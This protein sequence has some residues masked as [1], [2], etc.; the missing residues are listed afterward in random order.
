MKTNLKIYWVCLLA[1]VLSLC[2]SSFLILETGASENDANKIELNT[3]TTGKLSGNE[4]VNHFYFEV[5]TQGKLTLR[6]FAPDEISSEKSW[7]IIVLNCANDH[8]LDTGVLG[9]SGEYIS[10]SRVLSAGTYFIVVKN[11]NGETVSLSEYTLS[12]IFEEDTNREQE[13]NNSMA[14]ANSMEQNVHYKGRII[15]P[16]D[17]DY[18]SFVYE[19][20]SSVLVFNHVTGAGSTKLWGV[21]LFDIDGRPLGD[22]KKI[23]LNE[24]E[25][26][27]SLAEYELES[28]SQYYVLVS[29]VGGLYSPSEYTILL[30]T[31]HVCELVDVGEEES[32]CKTTGTIAHR[33][34]RI[35]GKN[36]NSQGEEI[37]NITSPLKDHSWGEWTEKQIATCTAGGRQER[38]CLN[39]NKTDS[40]NTDAKGHD[41]Q[42]QWTVDVEATCG[43]DGEKSHH[44]SRC[45]SRDQIT[46]I[47]KKSDAH[48][49]EQTIT[50]DQVR[51][52]DQE[53][54]F[55]R[56][57]RN[58]S[59]RTDVTVEAPLGH[60]MGSPT[61]RV[62]ASCS[63]SGIERTFCSR[64]DHFE[65]R[66]LD[67]LDHDF[68]NEWTVDQAP[69]CEGEGLESRHC[70]RCAE[71][72]EAR[73]IPKADHASE[74]WIFIKAPTCLEQ[75]KLQ[76][77]CIQCRS[78]IYK[79]VDALGH[80]YAEMWETDLIP[81][82]QSVGSESRHCRRC[83]SRTNVR[84]I[85]ALVHS[86]DV[87]KYDEISHWYECACGEKLL[88]QEHNFQVFVLEEATC[89]RQG[90]AKYVCC[91]C[92][93]R[94]EKELP[95][96]E[97]RMGEWTERLPATCYQKGERVRECVSGCGDIEI[98]YLEKLP[99]S[100]SD[101]W[102]VDRAP[103]CEQEG[104]QSHHCEF[105]D[106]RTD[107]VPIPAIGHSFRPWVEIIAP[108][109]T[110]K[111]MKKR[112][113]SRCNAE[114]LLE[115]V[116]SHSYDEYFTVDIEA[117]CETPGSKSRH[118]RNCDERVDVT[119]LSPTGHSYGDWI[120]ISSPSCTEKGAE[121]RTCS[122]CGSVEL[123]NVGTVQNHSFEEQFTVDAAATCEATGSKSRHCRNCDE[124]IDVTELPPTGHSYGDWIEISSPT[125]TEKGV[126]KR[127]CS[128]CGSEELQFVGTVLNHCFEE[129]FTVDAEAT[130]E[131]AGSK[132]RHCRNCD[133]RTDVT[134]LSPTGHLFG[135]WTETEV[136]TCLAAAR[137]KRSCSVCQKVEWRAGSDALGHAFERTW[138]VDIQ[139]SCSS[140]G[141][142]SRHCTRCEEATDREVIPKLEHAYDDGVVRVSPTCE[143]EGIKIFTCT[144]C[145][146]TYEI[147]LEKL[148]PVILDATE[149]KWK[150]KSEES[151]TFRS[152]A[153]LADFLE[154]R[155]NGEIVSE[156]CYI[157]REGST[158]V[159]L[160]PEYLKTLEGGVYTLEI[161]S[162]TG[163]AS[164]S[165]EVDSSTSFVCLWITLMS[166][167][168]VA[169]GDII[170]WIVY[171]QK[172]G[173]E[174]PAPAMAVASK[175][176]SSKTKS[177][178][179]NVVQEKS[180]PSKVVQPK[181]V[182]PRT[183]QTAE[184]S[185]SNA[186]PCEKK[187]K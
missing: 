108:T 18:F 133:E 95:Y 4:D 144:G 112:T 42:T 69:T 27:I 118:C 52:C 162:T 59:E 32:T 6:F 148:S 68:E 72:T 142:K 149:K 55:S 9:G 15:D 77:V 30:Q 172:M 124:R 153:A 24:P 86:W 122:S 132:S 76:G 83:S 46:V 62:V 117:T 49:F 26:R 101:Q 176:V 75:G 88:P 166:V 64:C 159:E 85:P 165:F 36:Y 58:C 81:T 174:R 79:E 92:P 171:I 136:P 80:D 143:R 87:Q 150:P 57:C 17:K 115:T 104:I 5:S 38:I 173:K 185:K 97:H 99:H 51:T 23:A 177:I 134:E 28:G 183:V 78:I 50:Q 139:P 12:L 31:A 129:H 158:I 182:Q 145:Q 34:C 90:V 128:S 7:N 65:D 130:C 109:C 138:T 74:T 89:K 175:A 179:P 184:T 127:I 168:V 120:E 141:S 67:K 33:H 2:F 157:L 119:E 70:K 29:A 20:R 98:Q 126:E 53:G 22:I 156:D 178:Q 186:F 123:K 154:V 146:N 187:D 91:D 137:E 41:Y 105:C 11:G 45:S 96:K 63:Q 163:I 125:C 111:G 135:D 140:S 106:G 102:T 167:A 19:D 94:C 10:P 1:G 110:E 37:S 3:S 66:V 100:Y 82:C 61:V 44:C 155:V 84:E 114:E 103:T 93:Y 14:T 21:R 152:A 48:D 71:S 164:A 160:T 43:Q 25:V 121:K 113:C 73:R 60:D 56:H 39:C 16:D 116:A 151:M 54:I 131:V 170:I 180:V 147:S 8:L 181:P 13:P 161:V 169:V 47:P 107:V 35:C 40:R